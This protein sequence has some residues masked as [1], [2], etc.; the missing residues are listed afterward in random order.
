VLGKS[1][2]VL[3]IGGNDGTLL[4]S[5]LS[6]NPDL[7]VT[8]V[9]ASENIC[10]L[11]REKGIKT[12]N[13][14]WGTDFSNQL[15]CK[16]DLIVST[17]VFQHTHEINNFVD[18]ISRSLSKDGLW[19]LEFPYW[20]KTLET[21]QYDQ[22]Y[23]EHI[24]YYLITPISLLLEKYGLQIFK[25]VERDIHGGTVRL[26]IAHRNSIG[27]AF[28]E[29]KSVQKYLSNEKISVDYY[30]E[31]GNKIKNHIKKCKEFILSLK[32]EGKRIAGFGAAAKGCVFLNTVGLDYNTIDY[33]IDDTDLKQGKFIP[34]T[35]IEIFSRNKLKENEVDYLIILAHNFSDY[36]IKSLNGYK[37][38]FIIMM[39]EIKII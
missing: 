6:I 33:V 22:I 3:D 37:G 9:D 31:W 15:N 12:I 10:E 13:A 2:K 28:H 34:G 1:K 32:K 20:K 38:K 14:F 23:H 27:K 29:C 8:N 18:A 30:A 16:F 5:F 35:G 26:L 24:Y 36:I 39:P 19:C 4:S 11:S 17:N 25:V 21:Y 7:D